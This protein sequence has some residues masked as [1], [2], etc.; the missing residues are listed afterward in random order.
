[1]AHATGSVTQLFVYPIKSC[2][3]MPLARSLVT[4]LGLEYDRQWLIVNELGQFQTQRQI[5][6]L[7]WI[8]P[9]LMA[10]G[11]ELSAP[12]HDTIEVPY[13]HP[14]AKRLE[15]K[16]W[17]DQ[18]PALD[19][20]DRAAA[21]LNDYLEVPGRQFRLV[22]FDP[23]EQRLS[24]PAWCAQNPA[25]LQFADGFAVNVLSEASLRHFNE[26]LMQT[27]AQPVEAMRFRPNIVVD[28]LGAHEEDLIG[29][30]RVACQGHTLELELVKPCPRCKVPEINPRTAMHEPEI[31]E[32]L[33]QYRQ[34][35]RMD[36]AICFGMNAVVR[37]APHRE[38]S[39]G[40][41]FEAQLRFEDQAKS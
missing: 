37:Q 34:I 20:G 10:N 2:A 1:M 13:A 32:V 21:W 8:E 24:D 17:K 16:V 19:M 38:L 33:A 31:G 23:S 39:V 29:T 9:R 25:G 35:P 36:H 7:A 26:R 15:I 11:I 18:M 6:H 27:G 40:D 5:P 12:E 41:R 22:Q 14:D 30:M 4:D 28:G 3:G